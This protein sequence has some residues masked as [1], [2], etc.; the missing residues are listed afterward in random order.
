M[1]PEAF[2]SLLT[3]KSL[4]TNAERSCQ[5]SNTHTTSAG[6]V[7]LQD[8]V[9]LFFLACAL[10]RSPDTEDLK[11]EK[12]TFDQL[13]AKLRELNVRVA[14]SGTMSAMNRTRVVVKHYGQ[15]CAPAAA[16]T[17]LQA[18]R[19]AI[20][21]AV[22]DVFGLPLNGIFMTALVTECRGKWYLDEA[23]RL[24]E[25][26]DY[27]NCLSR[28]RQALFVEFEEDYFV[29]DWAVVPD[30]EWQRYSYRGQKAPAYARDPSW[31]KGRTDPTQMTVLDMERLRFDMLEIGASVQDFLN[32]RNKTPELL[33]M[34]RGGQW[35]IGLNDFAVPFQATKE[36]AEYCIDQTVMLVI[37]KQVHASSLVFDRAP[38]GK[39]YQRTIIV[40]APVR[41]FAS[42]SAPVE[43]T[44][45]IGTQ[46][47][48]FG[49]TSPIDGQ[50]EMFAKALHNV[51]QGVMYVPY[52]AVAATLVDIPTFAVPAD[53]T[54]LPDTGQ[55]Q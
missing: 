52:S 27:M 48:Y 41:T 19:T 35:L 25:A 39:M 43:S 40:P 50:G 53:A 1:K 55:I 13:M 34:S 6:V 22:Q 10:E 26:G 54:A 7:M 20:D 21:V 42:H 45:P 51:G 47:I 15:A 2:H 16:A 49:S 30:V 38:E 36:A 28:T 31:V 17:Y 3:A 23:V 9:E 29:G 24:F 11:L 32:V 5:S 4:F 14:K 44:L 46:L 37:K 33:E 8:A 18:A 12:L